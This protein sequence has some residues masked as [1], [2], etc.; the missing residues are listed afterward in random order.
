[1]FEQEIKKY[2]ALNELA[3]AGGTVLFGGTADKSIPLCELKQAF[4]LTE[5]LYNRSFTGL[6]VT[7]AVTAYDSCITG[8]N[9]DCVLLH[10][11]EEDV[12]LFDTDSAT[13]EQH[14]RALVQHIRK[15]DKKCTIGIISLR[16]PDNSEAISELNKS[17]KYIAES[18][19]C[20]FEDISVKR[21][22]NPK[23]MKDVV[24]FV[25]STG[26]VR[27]LRNKRPLYDLVKIL[28]CST[29]VQA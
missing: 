24:S 21:V 8:L 27:P 13:F 15:L 3:E 28:F 1:M 19:R 20:E 5:K 10:I 26:F 17:L 2:L 12:T 16:N 29:P 11:G 22:W 25:Y 7:D 4:S 23:E 18:E 6:S 14:F 9:P